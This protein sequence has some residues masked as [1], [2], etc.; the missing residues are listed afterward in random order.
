[1]LTERISTPSATKACGEMPSEGRLEAAV[2][3]ECGVALYSCSRD[4]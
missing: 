2:A 3:A 4:F 1:V